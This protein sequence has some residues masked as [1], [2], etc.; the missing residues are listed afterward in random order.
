MPFNLGRRYLIRVSLAKRYTAL[1]QA[2]LVMC[3]RLVGVKS[4]TNPAPQNAKRP[5]VLRARSLTAI[6]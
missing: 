2:E 1:G 4:K 5:D 6:L 3:H